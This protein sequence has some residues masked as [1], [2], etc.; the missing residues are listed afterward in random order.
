MTWAAILKGALAFL[1]ALFGFVEA[2]RN[3]EL[4]RLKERERADQANDDLRAAIDRANTDSVSD[5][6]IVR[7]E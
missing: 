6:E 4:G 1:R 5:D 7:R 2:R 3:E